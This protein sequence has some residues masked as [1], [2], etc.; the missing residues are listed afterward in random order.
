MTPLILLAT[1]YLGLIFTTAMV[2]MWRPLLSIGGFAV[3][4]IFNGV[5]SVMYGD[6]S[7]TT[8]SIALQCLDVFIYGISI[9]RMKSAME[10]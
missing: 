1:G 4:V 8:Q 6:P 3:N 5:F 2:F 9:W 7:K 10:I